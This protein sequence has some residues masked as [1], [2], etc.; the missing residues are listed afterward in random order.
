VER[1]ASYAEVFRGVTSVQPA[2]AVERDLLAHDT[3]KQFFES[4]DADLQREPP[5]AQAPVSRP[6]SREVPAGD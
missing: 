3:A 4:I 2:I 5:L 1:G 6:R